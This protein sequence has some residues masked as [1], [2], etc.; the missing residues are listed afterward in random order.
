MFGTKVTQSD[1]REV[2]CY[3]CRKTGHIKKFCPL[4]KNKNNGGGKGAGKDSKK[5]NS[6]SEKKK[7]WQNTNPD[8]KLTMEKNG[9]TFYW[10]KICNY[11]HGKLVDHKEEVCPYWRKQNLD[12]SSPDSDNAG[13]MVMDLVE[14]GFLAI[15]LL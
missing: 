3:K 15:E 11:G 12:E 2:V 4:N 13:L 6:K 10:C 9:K 8:N 7:K 14:S 5:S 1:L